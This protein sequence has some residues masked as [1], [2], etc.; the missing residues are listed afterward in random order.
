MN[1]DKLLTSKAAADFLGYS[2][3]SLQYWRCYGGGPPFQRHRGRSIRYRYGD[4]L[5]WIDSH[6]TFRSTSQSTPD[7]VPVRTAPL[8]RLQL[9]DDAA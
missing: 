7:P 9:N 8:P 2:P 3:H 5:A 4:L 6:G 1:P